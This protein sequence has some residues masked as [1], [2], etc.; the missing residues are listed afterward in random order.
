MIEYHRLEWENWVWVCESNSTHLSVNWRRN[1]FAFSASFSL[2]ALFL[3]LFAMSLWNPDIAFQLRPAF[4]FAIWSELA[5]ITS[6]G[7]S[8]QDTICVQ[9]CPEWASIRSKVILVLIV[10]FILASI[11]RAVAA[12]QS[13]FASLPDKVI[14]LSPPCSLAVKFNIPLNFI[15]L[16]D[17]Q[18]AFS[19]LGSTD[20]AV[21]LMIDSHGLLA[22]GKRRWW[23]FRCTVRHW[24]GTWVLFDGVLMNWADT[25]WSSLIPCNK[26]GDNV[27]L[28]LSVEYFL[29]VRL[30]YGFV[31]IIFMEAAHDSASHHCR[32]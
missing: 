19:W 9:T 30:I 29:P 12:Y 32:R 15:N 17:L 28:I 13:I 21:T 22:C 26:L 1:T 27:F 4:S 10:P 8:N 31:R 25:D 6:A 14:C 2:S 24:G 23:F 18:N 20:T 7:R 5:I 11:W 3:E 16:S